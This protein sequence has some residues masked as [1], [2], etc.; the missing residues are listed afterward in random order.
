MPHKYEYQVKNKNRDSYYSFQTLDEAYDFLFD[1]D[2]G[3]EDEDPRDF[4]I[5]TVPIGKSLSSVDEGRDS[6]GSLVKNFR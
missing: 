2:Y 1:Y 5:K 6:Q 3:L 4:R